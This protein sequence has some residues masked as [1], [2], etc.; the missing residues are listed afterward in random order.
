MDFINKYGITMHNEDLLLQAL[1]HTSYAH[2]NNVSEYE[3]LEFLGDAVIQLVVSEYLYQNNTHLDEGEMSK[4]RANYVCENALAHYAQSVGFIPYIRVGVG[5][6][7]NVN[8]TIIADIFE[9]ICGAIYL[10]Q[11]FEI[12]KNFIYKTIIPAID[13]EEEF[14]GDYKSILQELIQTDKKS[15][16]YVVVKES[17]PAHQKEFTVEARIDG[18]VYGKGIG[19]S[20]KTAE[21]KAAYDAYQK[22]AKK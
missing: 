10:D 8:D 19:Y 7:S 5:Q 1:T 12:V 20:K 11:G 4:K 2:E 17:G 6:A 3:R 21:Q 15:I 22:Q 18:M 13:N 14:F 16:D 9:S